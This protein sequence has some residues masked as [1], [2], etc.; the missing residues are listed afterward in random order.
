MKRSRS[1]ARRK[2]A[3][4]VHIPL[5]YSD[6]LSKSYSCKKCFK[7]VMTDS[8][9]DHPELCE[10]CRLKIERKEKLNNIKQ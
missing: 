10:T 9:F 4:K 2:S 1:K 3:R 7:L 5:G 6:L 8:F